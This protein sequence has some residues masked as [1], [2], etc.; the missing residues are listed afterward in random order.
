MGLNRKGFST[1]LDACIFTVLIIST[2]PLIFI[3]DADEPEPPDHAGM[4]M[5]V[6]M[7][8]EVC[9]D[10]RIATTSVPSRHPP[11]RSTRPTPAPR[12]TPPNVTART[13]SSV[14]DGVFSK[15]RVIT[16]N[17]AMA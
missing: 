4:L 8:T 11:A 3:V 2:V 1:L 14:A 7:S 16:E 9:F 5:D 17:R 10:R 13:T 6:I 12:R 15:I